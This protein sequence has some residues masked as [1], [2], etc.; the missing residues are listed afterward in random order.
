M[1]QAASRLVVNVTAEHIR[2]GV[3]R[4]PTGCPLALASRPWGSECG[5]RVDDSGV[6]LTWRPIR[7]FA[8]SRRSHRFMRD[9]D[10]GLPVQPSRFVLRR[11]G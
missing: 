1:S 11:V 10:A 9:F 8:H 6:Y 7:P 5:Q 3:P 4:D 2:E